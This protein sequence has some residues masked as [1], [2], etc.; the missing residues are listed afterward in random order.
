MNQKVAIIIPSCDRYSDVWPSFFFFLRKYWSDRPYKTYLLAN[1]IDCSEENVITVKLGPDKGWS[2][3]FKKALGAIK[4]EWILILFEDYFFTESVKGELIEE[5]HKLMEKEKFA[6][7]RLVPL[8]PPDRD[9]TYDRRLGIIDKGSAYRTSLQAA[10]WDRDALIH[11]LDQV[12]TPWQFELDGSKLSSEIPALFLSVKDE[13]DAVPM[14]YYFTAVVQGKWMPGAIALCRKHG[15][16]LDTSRR[17]VR[18]GIDIAW[19]KVRRPI[20]IKMDEV[21]NKIRGIEP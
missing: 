11:I 14:R 17:P 8:P 18:S 1:E 2:A 20:R 16:P 15:A 6:Y 10:I 4:E 3:N 5:Y 12:D 7:L 21:W 13:S 9:S 19:Q